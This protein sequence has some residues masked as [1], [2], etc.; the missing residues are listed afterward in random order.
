[1][2]PHLTSLN[3]EAQNQSLLTEIARLNRENQAL[4]T[5]QSALA[6]SEARWQLVL[7]G[8]NDG[9]W[10]WNIATGYLFMSDRWKAMLGYCDEELSPHIDTWIDLL[11]PQDRVSIKEA[12]EAHFNHQNPHYEIEF[13]LRCREGSYK[14]ILSRGQ[15]LWDEAGK[16][17]RMAGSH[18]DISD[19]KTEQTFL[20]S[21]IDSI[22]D[23]IFYKDCQGYYKNCNLAFENCVGRPSIEI[24]QKTDHRR[25][26]HYSER[27]RPPHG[28]TRRPTSGPR[29]VFGRR[30]PLRG[31]AHGRGAHRAD[32]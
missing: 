32:R 20:R 15:A 28:R 27:A 2:N 7:Q 30:F 25:R 29:T 22:P 16:P 9:I 21:L 31:K 11:H 1:M 5:M 10:D 24:A 19:R 18:T 4:Q 26:A 12:V 14:W 3:L 17:I 13:R 8:T 6:E 23:L